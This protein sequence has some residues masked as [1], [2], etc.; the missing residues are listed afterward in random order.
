[1]KIYITRSTA[2]Q[3]YLVMFEG[4]GDEWM[5][6]PFGLEASWIAVATHVQRCYPLAEI[7]LVAV[8]NS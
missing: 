4:T 7:E 2:E 6:L 1:M 3:C 8:Q 5:A